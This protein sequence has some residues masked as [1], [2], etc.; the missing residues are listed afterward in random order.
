MQSSCRIADESGD[1]SD[2]Q[3]KGLSLG[4]AQLN[5][6]FSLPDDWTLVKKLGRG[7]YGKVMEVI[8]QPSE[9][10]YACKRFEHVFVNEQ[11]ARCLLR[12]MTILKRLQHP[13]INRIICVLT[14]ESIHESIVRRE[15][16]RNVFC[17]LKKLPNT[18]ID[19][20]FKEVYLILRL[21][22]MDLKKLLKSGQF[23][24]ED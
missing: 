21:A 14:P 3:N 20:T 11:R 2:Q 15:S 22:D 10:Q 5:E 16:L 6:D 19:K 8:H 17:A 7:A 23:L 4:F 24:E 1:D 9:R 18:D 13:C 12:E